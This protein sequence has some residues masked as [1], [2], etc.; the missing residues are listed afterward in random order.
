VDTVAIP[1]EQRFRLSS[2]P[3]E[4][5]VAIRDGLG[6]RP[7]RVTYDRG[8]LE[9]MS[10]SNRHENRKKL[11]GRLIE[12]LTEEMG[13]DIYSS[14][15]MTFQREDLLRGLEPDECYWVENEPNVRGRDD[16]DLEKDPPPDLALEV[17]IT[18]S[19]LDR[20]SIYAALGVPEVWRWD[21]KTLIAHVRTTRGTYRKSDRSKAFPFL[22]LSE[23][24]G[25]LE[26]T[27]LS[28]TQLLRSFRAW[29]RNQK[30]QNWKPAK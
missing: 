23:F 2:I 11:L 15:S 17:E 26:P 16:L 3:W 13:I 8:E 24:A 9:I 14:G 30:K 25:F 18:R 21:G 12:A 1:V 22:P 27:K 5:Y 19:A 10:P 29:V 20:M 4:G 28:E 7:V 6:E